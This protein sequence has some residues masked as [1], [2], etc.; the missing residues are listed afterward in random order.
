VLGHGAVALRQRLVAR[1]R[2]NP[3]QRVPQ[4]L[5]LAP[6]RPRVLEQLVRY[7]DEV[8]IGRPRLGGRMR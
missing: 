4:L 7:P 2:A 6:Q 3:R 5:V 1:Q 8:L